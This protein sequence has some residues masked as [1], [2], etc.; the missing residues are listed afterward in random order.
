MLRKNQ[1]MI[2]PWT[3]IVKAIEP[4]V[5]EL[6]KML[7]RGPVIKPILN[8]NRRGA[9]QV[10]LDSDQDN[11]DFDYANYD[12]AIFNDRIEWTKHEAENWDAWRSSYDTWVFS[13]KEDAEK[14][15]TYYILKWS[16]E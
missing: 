3:H 4:R 15:I 16:S 5:E 10:T 14:F 9:W 7:E 8:R 11:P 2:D 12:P 13:S 6:Q 1:R